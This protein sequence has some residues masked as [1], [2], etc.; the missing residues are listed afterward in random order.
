MYRSDMTDTP[1]TEPDTWSA[2]L[3]RAADRSGGV[4]ALAKKAGLHHDTIYGYL[5][6]NRT[7]KKVTI[8]TVVAIAR[9]SGDHPVQAFIAAAGLVEEEP[10]DRE[11]GAILTSGLPEDEQQRLIRGIMRKREQDEERR[12]SDTQELIRYRREQR[13]S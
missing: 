5:S 3:Q 11:I 1:S 12:M 7:M 2:Y 6:A 9:A 8:E 4:R 10:E 13:A